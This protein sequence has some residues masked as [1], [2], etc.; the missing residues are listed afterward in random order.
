MKIYAFYDNLE[1]YP[2]RDNY[3]TLIDI[4]QKSWKYYG[5]EPTILTLNDVKK[6]K[7]YQKLLE[8]SKYRPTVNR[9]DF[10]TICFLRWLAM[11]DKSGWYCDVDMINYGFEPISY[12]DLVVTTNYY[13]ALHVSCFYMPN[14]K[15][16][17]LIDEIINYELQSD[18]VENIN[19]VKIPHISDM[20]IISKTK[21]KI[22]KCLGIYSEYKRSQT[23][24]KDLI[25]HYT[26][27]CWD[28]DEKDKNKSRIDIIL[29][30]KRS[31]I[32]YY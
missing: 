30:D 13:P 15:Y 4:W 11:F 16:N 5:W 24:Q 26:N 21:I 6:H 27:C 29:E 9:K 8:I 32:F 2:C 23:W 31:K 17:N 3:E 28:R 20:H 22:D 12:D 18:D 19:G 1:G 10:E 14:I 25:V 7:D